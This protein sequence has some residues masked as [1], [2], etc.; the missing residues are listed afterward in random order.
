MKTKE[1][2]LKKI[3]SCFDAEKS[4]FEKESDGIYEPSYDPYYLVGN[5]FHIY[6]LY[7]MSEAELNNLIRFAEHINVIIR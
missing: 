6:E 4:I 1:E 3:I 2:I 5:C 7:E